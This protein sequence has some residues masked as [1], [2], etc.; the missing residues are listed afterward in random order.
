MNYAYYIQFLTQYDPDLI[1]E[2]P[3]KFHHPLQI[4]DVIQLVDEGEYHLVRLITHSPT[5]STLHLS[6]KGQDIADLFLCEPELMQPEIEG[7]ENTDL[8]TV[9]AWQ[10][11][12][13]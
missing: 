6:G 2:G 13:R 10:K 1:P 12:T 5:G 8:G 7:F 9:I 4:G 11:A 3:V